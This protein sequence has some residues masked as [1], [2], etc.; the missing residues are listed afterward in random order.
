MSA[1]G[2]IAEFNPLHTGHIYLIREAKKYGAAVV[3]MSGN[4]VQRGDVAIA[5]KRIRAKAALMCGADLVLELPVSYSLST[6]QNF[7]LGGVSVLKAAGCDSLMFGSECGEIKQLAEACVVLESA[8]FSSTVSKL[9]ATGITFAAAREKAAEGS[10][11]AKGLLSG[12]NN[13]LAAEYMLAAKKINAGFGF[14]TVTR[15]GAAHDSTAAAGGYASASLLRQKLLEGDRNFCRAYMP[16][17]VLNLFESGSIADIRRIERAVLAVLRAKTID[18]LKKLPDI[19]EGIE[20]KIFSAIRVATGLEE[21]YNTVKVKRYTHAR[22]RRLVLNT[23]LGIDS[24]FFMKPAPYVR[25]LGFS[26]AGEELLRRNAPLSPVPVIT[27]AADT[28]KLSADAKWLFEA[29]CRATDLF[30]L[31]LPEIRPCGAEYTEKIIKTEC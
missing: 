17:S 21:L 14:L 1:V 20:N 4:F 27:R 28:A 3:A 2:I 5:D 23:F 10:G 9:L 6:T 13:N 12:A 30:A 19:S 8:E 24:R 31:A 7:A 16:D 11:I 15:K 18:E 22:I 29:E 26:K 25:V